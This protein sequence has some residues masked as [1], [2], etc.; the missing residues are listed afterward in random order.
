MA[1][2]SDAKALY[3]INSIDLQ[4]FLFAFERTGVIDNLKYTLEYLRQ[5][6]LD[7]RM[8]TALEKFVNSSGILFIS[9]KICLPIYI[10]FHSACYCIFSYI[11]GI[12]D[13]HK[14]NIL[15]AKDGTFF[16]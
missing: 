2:K 12:G 14:E 16:F 4:Y 5:F 13:R 9:V 11:L 3:D 1:Q 6:N 8:P 15:L 10:T 7:D